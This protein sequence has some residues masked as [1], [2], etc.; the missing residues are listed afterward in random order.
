MRERVDDD[1]LFFDEV[2]QPFHH[3]HTQQVTAPAQNNRPE[4]QTTYN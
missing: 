4:T 2:A 3:R 1:V